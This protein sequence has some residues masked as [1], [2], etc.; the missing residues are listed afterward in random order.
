MS[1][2]QQWGVSIT[3]KNGERPRAVG[4]EDKKERQQTKRGRGKKT[5]AKPLRTLCY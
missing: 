4:W 3:A 5:G 1:D 2:G